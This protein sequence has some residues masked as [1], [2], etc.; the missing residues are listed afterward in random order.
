MYLLYM[1]IVFVF[2][3]LFR[4]FHWMVLPCILFIYTAMSS[5]VHMTPRTDTYRYTCPWTHLNC[6]RAPEVIVYNMGSKQAPL[7]KRFKAAC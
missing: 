4:G 7:Q 5:Y 1:Y 3:T 6:C 2:I